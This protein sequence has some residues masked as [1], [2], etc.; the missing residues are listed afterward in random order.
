M[1]DASFRPPVGHDPTLVGVA[2]IAELLEVRGGT[3]HAWRWR[4]IMPAPFAV[5]SGRPAWRLDV[6][7]GW[8]D[9]TGRLPDR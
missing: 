7:L 1:T 8:A 3:V 6:V 5:I 4:R 9:A 2:E